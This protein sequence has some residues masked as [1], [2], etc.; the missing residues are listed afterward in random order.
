MKTM[1]GLQVNN[2]RNQNNLNF[3]WQ[4]ESITIEMEDKIAQVTFKHLLHGGE[5]TFEIDIVAPGNR[6]VSAVTVML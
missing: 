5:E 4:V 6:S 2:I 3:L 1:L